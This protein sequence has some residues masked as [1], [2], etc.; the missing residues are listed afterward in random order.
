MNGSRSERLPVRLPELVFFCSRKYRSYRS[1]FVMHRAVSSS[2]I[3]IRTHFAPF[4]TKRFVSQNNRRRLRLNLIQTSSGKNTL[5]CCR[6]CKDLGSNITASVAVL[7]TRS[8][9]LRWKRVLWGQKKRSSTVFIRSS[10]T[11]SALLNAKV[12]Y[13]NKRIVKG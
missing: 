8:H 12:S 3:R 7:T 4:V 6:R 11:T 1:R 5:V 13:A 10:A 9:A 2:I